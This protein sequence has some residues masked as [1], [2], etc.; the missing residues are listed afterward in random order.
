MKMY[1][2]MSEMEAGKVKDPWSLA[3]S[4]RWRLYQYWLSH[5]T[6]KYYEEIKKHTEEFEEACTSLK[7]LKEQQDELI[8]RKADVIAMTTTCAARYRRILKNIGP[9]IVIIE[10]A[11]EVLE[12]HVVTSLTPSLEHLILI[13]DHKQLR[14]NPSVYELAKKYNL[15]LSLFERMVNN[16]M[17]C[18]TLNVQHRM[19]PE[20]SA[21]IKHVYPVLENHP[22]V[23]TY[24]HVKGVGNDVMF[25]SHQIPEKSGAQKSKTN[26]YEAEYLVA[27]CRYLLLQG[28]EPSQITILTG[29]SGQLTEMKRMMPKAE[30]E[31][32]RVTTVDNFQGEENDVILLSLV[33]SN[34]Q[35][36]IGFLGTENRVNVALS[37]AKHGLYVIGNFNLLETKSS[38]WRNIV[39]DCRKTG[40][41]VTTLTLYCQNH[42]AT[43][44]EVRQPSD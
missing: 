35:G 17:K 37:R 40:K 3:L 33:R 30:F 23:L 38:L 11:A 36:S 26:K 24:P 16:G 44:L 39:G 9:K 19:R 14:P 4:E 22:K 15:E 13:G 31:G 29:Y 18:L 6:K 8:L 28:Y 21:L 32:V 1:K 25:I 41:L 42:P 5:Y 43:K 7:E 10:E 27:L 2:P 34:N 12:A 20:I